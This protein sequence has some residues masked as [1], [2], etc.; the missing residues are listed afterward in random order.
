MKNHKSQ[1]EFKV[2]YTTDAT[3]QYPI[4]TQMSV[5]MG[6]GNEVYEVVYCSHVSIAQA[7]QI[8]QDL[9][10]LIDKALALGITV[11]PPPRRWVTFHGIVIS[12]DQQTT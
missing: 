11:N 8:Q 5:P 2:E 10:K 4:M 7:Q 9:Q 12:N 6:V 3:S 1:N